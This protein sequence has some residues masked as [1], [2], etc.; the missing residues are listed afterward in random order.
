[1]AYILAGSGTISFEDM[2]PATVSFWTAN[3]HFVGLIFKPFVCG[4]GAFF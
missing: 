1:M 4:G 2:F 3:V